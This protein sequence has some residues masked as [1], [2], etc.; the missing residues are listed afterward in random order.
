MRGEPERLPVAQ[1]RNQ[2]PLAGLSVGWKFECKVA[3]VALVVFG[4]AFLE[5][6][7]L[8]GQGPDRS[9][10]STARQAHGTWSQFSSLSW[11]Y[12]SVN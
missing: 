1:K 7:G 2:I 6:L 4:A 11:Q 10:A 9:F 5:S 12:Y 3:E 8:Q